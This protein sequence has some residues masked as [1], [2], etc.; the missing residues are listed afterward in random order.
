MPIAGTRKKGSLDPGLLN[1]PKEIAEHVMLVDLARNDVGSVALPGTVR[2]AEFRA[3]Y[4]FSHV[5][6]MISRVVGTLRL[7]CDALDALKASFP[8]GTLTGAPKIRAMELIEELELSKRGLYGGAIIAIEANGNLAS[9]IAIRTA[10]F[11]EGKMFVRAGAGIVLDSDPMKEADE[12][13]FKA[14]AILEAAY[15]FNHR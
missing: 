9:C 14:S 6:H 1:D 10:L 7:E 4:H 2:V 3:V 13:V 12:T 11:T 8:A 5:E 15:A